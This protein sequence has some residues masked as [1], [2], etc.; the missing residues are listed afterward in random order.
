MYYP[1]EII[2]EIRVENNIIEVISEYINL[3]KKGNSYF[4]LCP[5]H[6][7]KTASFS[8]S[9]EKQMYYC[10]G[11]GAGGNVITFI[12]QKENYNFIETIQLLA[13]KRNILLPQAEYSEEVKKQ[14]QKKQI[15]LEIHKEAGRYFHFNLQ[16][17][18]GTEAKEYLKRRNIN[19]TV[20]KKFGLGYA[21]G[22]HYDLHQYLKKKNYSE[23]LIIQSGLVIKSKK[24]SGCYDRFGDRLMFPIFDVHGKVIAFGG[25][26]LDGSQPKYLNSPE[27]SLFE[28]NMNLYGLNY[29]RVSRKKELFIVEGYMDVIAM[30]QAGIEN[31]VATLGTAFTTGHAKLLK[32]YSNEVIL[33]YDSDDAGVRATLRAIP[34]LQSEGIKVRVLYLPGKQD[35]DDYIAA[36]GAPA[37]IKLAD[38]A[39]GAVSFQ[40]K[41]IK[42]K[43][44]M[45]N[46]EQKIR[47]I[48]ETATLIAE[49]QS[50]VEQE[51]YMQQVAMEYKIDSDALKTE[52]RKKM[53]QRGTRPSR[54]SQQI[55]EPKNGI[56]KGSTTQ[57]SYFKTQSELL[58]LMCLYP[59]V[60]KW[61][62]KHLSPEEFVD[63]F[64]NK[65]VA[66]IYARHTDGYIENPSQFSSCFETIE[67]QNKVANVFLAQK[68]Y[69]SN[70]MIEKAVNDTVRKLKIKGIE[71]RLKTTIDVKELQNLLQIKKET[72]KLYIDSIS[73]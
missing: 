2:E 14:I 28:K 34:I 38:E 13:N 70:E 9:E 26:V 37:L 23:E 35:P 16:E 59:K 61:V 29:A 69:D 48:D 40:I 15:L 63:P 3:T 52:I 39:I 65:L 36:N 64:F 4:G 56:I 27:T 7:E 55:T 60:L 46:V 32:K 17:E 72:D 8:V 1:E 54:L 19:D 42:Q 41:I 43:Y 66:L 10:F 20:Q 21:K 51:I 30:Y 53:H 71:K 57:D 47:F 33:L 12:M 58:Q 18:N 25:R 6:N 49:L 68:Q 24:G 5:F 67:E 45:E 11:C 22:N 62:Q 50:A 31:V 44:D 73:G